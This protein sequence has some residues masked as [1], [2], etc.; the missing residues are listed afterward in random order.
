MP[1]DI[2]DSQ[3]SKNTKAIL[4][5][6]GTPYDVPD[7]MISKNSM[8]I[9]DAIAAYKTTQVSEAPQDGKLYG[10]MDKT[11][12]VATGPDSGIPDAPTDGKS[13][14]RQSGGWDPAS[15]QLFKN[16]DIGDYVADT[17]YN[18]LCSHFYHQN[19]RQAI[20]ADFSPRQCIPVDDEQLSIYK[21][22]G[23][24]EVISVNDE[25]DPA[26]DYVVCS[27][28]P[29]DSIAEA[30]KDG[31][32]YGRNNGT[33]ARAAPYQQ[34]SYT[35]LS[36]A[37]ST[38][39]PTWFNAFSYTIPT[40]P[41]YFNNQIIFDFWSAGS[42]SGPLTQ[43]EGTYAF[44][45]RGGTIRHMMKYFNY[46]GSTLQTFRAGYIGTPALG[47]TLQFWF[48]FV[49]YPTACVNFRPNSATK[50]PLGPVYVIGQ[51]TE[52]TGIVYATPRA[53]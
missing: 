45:Y 40:T 48:Y 1:Y 28:V 3:K 24:L 34:Y 41:T 21:W 15:I 16:A 35:T 5:A 32:L 7:S 13:Y 47:A 12:V 31:N 52:P 37:A 49:S 50:L 42:D 22:I 26:L 29:L 39:V 43:I 19:G 11:W 18:I 36:D 38:N 9:L 4:N 33:W 51:S 23:F 27:Y 46:D 53:Y 44:A 14:V 10:R 2:P 8:A 20:V 30:P 17:E 25:G 6:L